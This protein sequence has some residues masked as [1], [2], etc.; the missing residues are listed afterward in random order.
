MRLSRAIFLAALANVLIP[1]GARSGAPRECG[2]GDTAGPNSLAAVDRVF[3][4][5]KREYEAALEGIRSSYSSGKLTKAHLCVA[6][7]LAH[8]SVV[9]DCRI[10]AKGPC[11]Q[12]H[13][14]GQVRGSPETRSSCEGFARDL[15]LVLSADCGR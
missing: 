2:V 3:P 6:Y 12:R 13:A 10:L 15:G 7:R 8:S 1:V 4:G 5:K 14:N 9:H 11:L